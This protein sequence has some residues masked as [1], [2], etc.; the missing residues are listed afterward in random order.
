M[1]ARARARARPKNAF[2]FTRFYALSAACTWPPPVHGGFKF[3]AVGMFIGGVG[4]TR[5]HVRLRAF[6]AFL[7]AHGHPGATRCCEIF[8]PAR[9]LAR[10]RAHTSCRAIS[11]I[12]DVIFCGY[13]VEPV[14]SYISRILIL[15]VPVYHMSRVNSHARLQTRARAR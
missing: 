11:D 7:R 2:I 3:R 12:F 1:H 6:R 10:A 5:N 14:E 9:S 4:N 8:V 15:R 13:P